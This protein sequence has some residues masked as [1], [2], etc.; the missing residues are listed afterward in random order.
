MTR[1]L[2]SMMGSFNQFYIDVF[3]L[4]LYLTE[5]K[6]SYRYDL[7]VINMNKAIE[8][9]KRYNS[10]VEYELQAVNTELNNTLQAVLFSGKALRVMK[11]KMETKRN[12]LKFEADNLK[13][14]LEDHIEKEKNKQ[15]FK[16]IIG[17]IRF[18]ANIVTGFVGAANAGSQIESIGNA[19]QKNYVS[20]KQCT[21][22][23]IFQ[24]LEKFKIFW[25][26]W[27]F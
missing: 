8:E 16:I 17:T 1:V 3:L 12:N 7:A 14:N 24:N 25:H 6:C 19:F 4:K 21:T 18:V 27:R 13:N 5:K 20:R 23:Q 9:S 2:P 26:C 22:L 11:E 10:E 15:I